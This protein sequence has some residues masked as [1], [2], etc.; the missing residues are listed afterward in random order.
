MGIQGLSRRSWRQGVNICPEIAPPTLLF[1]RAS[2]TRETLFS[3]ARRKCV[4]QL[5][6]DNMEHKRCILDD[7]IDTAEEEEEA[8]N[9]HS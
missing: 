3:I 9:F 4:N 6:S 5:S 1:H 8:A 7:S 2:N